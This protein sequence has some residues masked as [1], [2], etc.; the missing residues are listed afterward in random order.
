LL[1]VHRLSKRLWEEEG[2]EPRRGGFFPLLFLDFME[3]AR[4]AL[5]PEEAAVAAAD[6]KAEAEEGKRRGF[7]AFLCLAA[8]ATQSLS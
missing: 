3:T 4:G 8:I 2:K 1:R 5:L 6:E 7:F